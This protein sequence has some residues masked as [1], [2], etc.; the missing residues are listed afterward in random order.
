M[1]TARKGGTYS[2]THNKTD[3]IIC[4][5][6]DCLNVRGW[7]AQV[8]RILFVGPVHFL[9]PIYRLMNEQLLE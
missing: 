8:P 3:Q 5:E 2:E 9:K 4:G 6:L 7:T 1:A